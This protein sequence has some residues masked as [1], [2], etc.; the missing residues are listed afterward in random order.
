[1]KAGEYS[2]KIIFKAVCFLSD[3]KQIDIIAKNKASGSD[4]TRNILS[5]KVENANVTQ[6]INSASM[7]SPNI[8][9]NQIQEPK[10]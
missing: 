1:M 10:N 6:M 9:G 3:T 4:R 2:G 8:P 7:A 5:T